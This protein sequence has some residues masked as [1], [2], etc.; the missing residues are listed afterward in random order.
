M[1]YILFM[2]NQE[3]ERPYFLW[4]E[5]LS[6]EELRV[7]LNNPEHPQFA[8]YL[9]KTLREAD[10]NDVFTFVSVKT[11]SKCFDKV[12]PFLGRRREYWKFL[13]SGW[14]RLGYLNG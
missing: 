14:Q 1:N 10:F 8:Y 5:K 12:L 4:D 9:G 13:L 11:V 6:S 2:Q 7:I 3:S